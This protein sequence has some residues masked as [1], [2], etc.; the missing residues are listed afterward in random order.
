MFFRVSFYD[1][2]VLRL[3]DYFV[4]SSAKSVLHV[5]FQNTV[6]IIKNPQTLSHLYNF[7]DQNLN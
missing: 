6:K 7:F 3:P 2:N 1:R 4:M 5:P